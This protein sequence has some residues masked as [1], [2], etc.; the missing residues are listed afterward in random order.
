MSTYVYGITRSAHPLR[1]DE[2]TGVGAEPAP[3]R[4]IKSDGLAAVVSDAPDGL[5]PKRRDLE[6]HEDVLETLQDDGT[7]LPMR[8]GSLAPDDTA[9]RRELDERA[10]WYDERL[11]SLDG[12][13]EVNVK[14]FHREDAVLAGMLADREDLRKA[15]EA[16]RAS[17]G[18]DQAQQ[19][20]FGEKV[21]AALED[22]RA[23]DSAQLLAVLRPYATDEY[24]G[25]PVDGAFL[26]VSLLVDAD[27]EAGLREAAED[28]GQRAEQV[29][30]LRVSDPLPPYSFV[31]PA[32]G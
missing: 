25:P 22:V 21:A 1:V 32:G 4:V 23:R 9:V 14:A 16:M 8:F 30:E 15:N 12:R 13:R 29:V 26:N 11:T 17:G 2:R 31:V 5:R 27:Q 20:Q 7:V 18:G 24:Q 10:S 3:L 6:A 28:L 19:L